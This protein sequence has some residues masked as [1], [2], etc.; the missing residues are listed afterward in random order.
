MYPLISTKKTFLRMEVLR[1]LIACPLINPSSKNLRATFSF[2]PEILLILYDILSFP[3]VKGI[4]LKIYGKKFFNM[5][6]ILK[7]VNIVEKC[8]RL[9]N[10]L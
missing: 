2:S 9:H 7:Y 8:L 1:I 10:I 6:K 3:L 5:K 4:I